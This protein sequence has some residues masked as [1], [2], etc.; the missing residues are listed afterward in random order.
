MP[1]GADRVPDCAELLTPEW[2]T[3]ALRAGGAHVTVTDVRTVPVGQGNMA[4]NYRV[5]LTHDAP[6]VPRTMVVKLPNADPAA[7]ATV[8]SG[9]R[10]EVAFY[11]DLADTVAVRT[12]ACHYAAISAD[13]S[14]FVLMLEDLA[15]AEQG[16]QIAG[17]AVA[18]AADV[19]VNLAG[20]HGPRWCDPALH[21]ISWLP[22][23][24][25]E[26]ATFFAELLASATESF[27]ERFEHRL[28]PLDAVVLREV[29]EHLPEWLL[30]RPERFALLHGDYRLD[31]LMFPPDGAAGVAAVD[32]QTVTVGLP[33]RD[34]AYFLSTSLTSGDRRAHERDLVTTYH[35]A[36][37]GHGVAGY[38]P[39]D[40]FTDYRLGMLQ[41]PLITVL[42]AAYGQRSERGDDMFVAMAT[43][44]CAAIRDLDSL[45]LV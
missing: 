10:T 21:A 45:D 29:P 41:G 3:G 26:G 33:A 31:N 4:A 39:E 40:C 5:H 15:P 42:G 6:D 32:W 35:R 25:A 8:A 27:L 23:L 36:L 9:Y 43:R 14:T 19:V 44:S 2:V 7:R 17:C 28:Q 30:A 13:H 38:H 20:L 34:L 24:D 37:A 16:D 22:P 1:G 12:P 18:A 11:T